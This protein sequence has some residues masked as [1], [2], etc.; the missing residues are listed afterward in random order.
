MFYYCLGALALLSFCVL[1]MADTAAAADDKPVVILDT[2][3]GPITIELDR[4]RAPL[5]VD[6]FL[7]YVDEGHYDGTMFHRVIPNFMIQ[8]GGFAEGATN[9]RDTKKTRAPIKNEAGN[10]LKNARGTIAMAR[11]GD[12]NSATSQFFIN[13]GDDN[14]FLDREQ[15]QDGFGYAVFGKVIGG[16]DTVDK[17]AKIKTIRNQMSEGFPTEPVTIKTAKRKAS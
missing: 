17:I 8:G 9:P 15:S 7:K 3:F 4:A 11:T 13:L 12:P 16:M 10:G 5:S 14:G 6:N 1:P 2:N